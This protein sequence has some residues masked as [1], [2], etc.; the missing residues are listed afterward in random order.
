ML[1]NYTLAKNTARPKVL[2]I[3]ESFG[4]GVFT[5]LQMLI[6]N[7]CDNYEIVILYASR[8]ETPTNFKK[9]FPK[10]VKFIKSE[11]LARNL[12]PISDVK[13][14]LEARRVIK[15][16]NPDII[17][18]HSS[19]AGAIGRIACIFTTKTVL[20]NPHGFSFLM[21]NTSKIKRSFYKLAEKILAKISGTIIC[22]SHDEYLEAKKLTSKCV[23]ID[24]A[25]DT[26]SLEKVSANK[27]DA[28]RPAI[29][30][31][32]R[33]DDQKNPELFNS[34]A[35]ANPELS[36][37]WIGDGEMR[38]SLSSGNITVTGWKNHNETMKLLSQADIFML[39]SEWEGLSIALLEAMYLQKLCIVS[40]IGGNRSVIKNNVNG[41]VASD[42]KSYNKILG[43]MQQK[44][45]DRLVKRAREDIVDKYCVDNMIIKYRRLYNEV[46]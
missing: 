3:V 22:C 13:A 27:I 1:N 37:V 32:G 4:G 21:T 31:I 33:I 44:D 25:I 35:K 26:T 24:N 36:F 17:Q 28:K 43:K 2:H 7:T 18:L 15:D 19:K 14:I 23:H 11:H 5:F 29:C 16:E 30:T 9:L 46:S 12:N 41:Y 10:N 39:T 8:P 34:I 40:N 6:K 20:Y 42:E 38:D 45:A